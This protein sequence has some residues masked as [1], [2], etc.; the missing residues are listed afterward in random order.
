VQQLETHDSYFIRGEVTATVLFRGTAS[1]MTHVT[2]SRSDLTNPRV[3]NESN[4][5][6]TRVLANFDSVADIT[7]T[8]STY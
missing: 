3:D 2:N 6:Y 7:N 1:R 8:D 5:K 4:S